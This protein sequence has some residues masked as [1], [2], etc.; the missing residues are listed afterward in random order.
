MIHHYSGTI[1][2]TTSPGPIDTS[3]IGSFTITYMATADAAGN[4]PIPVNATVEI[5]DTTAP[6]ITVS[7]LTI[8]LKIGESYTP[9]TFGV[10]DNDPAYSGTVTA[11][12]TPS[13]VD[14]SSIG[15]FTV[16][17]SAPADASG[18][19]PDNVTTTVSVTGCDADQILD[20]ATNT[21]IT[22]TELPTI[23]I[24]PTSFTLEIDEPFTPPTV[25]ISDNDPD[26]SGTISNT[27]SPGPIDTSR[28]GSFTITY[29]ATADAAGNSP[30]PVNATVEIV[31][32]TAPTITVSNL[33]ITLKIG[34]SYTPPT[35]G[36]TDND[37][38]YSG[39]VTVT[40]AP[41]PVDT[42][43]IGSFTVTHSAPADASGNIPDNVTT[44]VSVT[45][46]DP[47]Q[48]L[49]SNINACVIDT[50]SPDITVIP[51]SITLEIDEPFTPPT[52]TLM[53]NDPSYAGTISNTTSPGPIDTSRIGSFTITYMATADVAGNSPDNVIATVEIVDTTAPTITVSNL[54]ITLK[55]GESYTPPTFGVTDND[56]AYS[57]SV[58]AITTPSA[59]DTSS[60]GSFT[61]THSAPADASGNIPD[62]VTTT[63][64]V[65]GCDADQI[66][67]SATNTCIT[68]TE[69]PTIEI[70][71]TSFTLEIDEPFTPPTV[72]ISDN[73]PDYSG[74]ISNTTSP[75]PID[76]SRIGSFTITYMATADAAGNSP[77]NV[78]ATVEIVD[79]TAPTITVSNLTITLKI[80]ESY[81]PPTFGVTD[82][83]PAYSGTVTAITTPSAVDTSSIG[84]FTVTHSA[85]ADASGNIPDNVTTTVSVTGC[86]AD[87]ILDSATNTC[88]TDTELPTIEINPTSFT[89][90]I[91]EPFT[92]PTVTISDNDPDY[93]GTISNTTSPGPIDTSRIGSFTITYMATADAAGNSPIP[94][95]ATVEIVDTT[96]PTITVSNLTITLKIGESYTPPTFGVTDNDPAYS[97]T[98]TV[99]V[100]PNPVD[101]SSIGSFTVTHSAPADASGNIPDNVTT[102][103]SV[104]G[105]DADQILDSATNTCITDTELPTI[106]INPTSFT[107]EI[108]EPFTPPTVTISDNDPDYSGTISNTTSPGPIDTSRIGSFTITYMAT[109]DVAGNSPDN[110]IATVE[111]VDTTAPTITVSNLTI[112]LKIGE[113]YTPPTFGVTDNDPAYSGT[114][115][116]ITTPSAVDTSSI[117]SFT[118][119]HSAPADASGNIPDNV[120]TTVSVTGCDADQI[121]DSATNTCI[122]DTELPTIEINP[123]SFTLEIDEPFTPPTV[124]IS[125]NDPDYSGTISNTTSPGPIDTSRIG[126]F[127]ITYMA[128]A[129]AAGNSPIPVNATVEIVDTTAP[130][131]TVSNLTIT[132]KIGESYTPPTF[133]VTDNDPA[134]SGTVTAITTPSAVD[135]SS[136]GSFTV[137]HSAPADASGN[138]PDNVTTTVSVTGCDADQILDSATNTCITDTELPTIEINPTSFTLEIDEP[139]T[140]PTVT[141]SDN[142]PDYSGTISNTTSPGPIDTSRIGSFTITYMA[143]ADAAGNSP[144]PV[145]A[146]V[147]IV[148]TT[149][150]TITVSNLTI[151]LK[152]GE[153]YTPPTFGVTDNDP[154][155]SGTVTAITTPSA[156]DTSSIGSF[157]VTH[158]APADASGNIPDN[159]T[160]TVSVTGCD[161][162]QILDSAT[163]TCIT[164]TELPTIEINPTSFTLEIDEPFTPPTVTISDN[165]P[166]YSGTISNTTSPGPID[167][168]RIGS[169]TI[170]YMATADAA[171]N[172]PIPVN[173]TV[174]IVDTTAPTITVSNLT[175]T[176]KIGE[177]YTPPTFGVTDNDP[178]YSGSVTAITTPSAVDTSSI[179]SFTVTHSAPAD[180]SGNI[181]DNVTTTVSVTGCD[182]DQILD[183]AT[184]TCITDTELPTIEINPTS[185]TL[186]IDEPFTPPTVTISDNDPDYSGTIS[187]TTSPG[188]IDTSRI[189]SFTITYMA[190][191]DAAGNSPIPVNATVEIVD[192][193][194]PTI[195][196]SNLTITLK[197]G[198]SYTPPTFGVTDNDPAYS[199]TVTAITTPSAVDTSSIGSFT[200]T[201]SAP[202]DAS[203]NIPDNVTTTV[204]VTGCDADQILD[205]ATN[206]CIT[207]TELPTIEINPTSF[208]L[209]IDEPFTP[210]TV[211]ISDNDPDYSGTISN[212][213][214]PG[215]ID[216]SRIGSF[217]ITYMATA[218]AAGNSPI[219]VNA[220][221]E[222]VDTTAPTITVSNLT[223]T[224]KIGES[225]TPPTF[226]VTDNDPAYSGTVTVTVAPNPVDTSSIG[227]FTVTH[228][229]PADASGN[230]PDNVTTTVSVTG[231]DPNQILDSNINACVIDTESPDITVIPSSI[232]LEIDE[233]FTPPTVTLM[234]NDPSYAGTISNTTSPGPID[235]SRIG[236]F[237]I[238]YMATADVAGNS[239]DNVIATVEIVDT[240]APT[241]T[242]SNLT[243]TLK[244]GE[245]YTPPTFGV[246]DN[247]PAYSGSVT[248]ITTP[249]A[250]DT[251]SIGSFTVTHS[252][253]AD[254]SGNIPDNV[255]TTVSVTG[256]DADQILDSATN[257]CITDTELPTIEINPTSFTLEID[258]PFTPPTVT[259]S[260]N[261]PDYSGTISNTTSPGPIDTSRIGS[262]TITYMATADA[263]G[264]SPDNVIATVEIVDTT[265]PTITVSNLTITLKIGESYT[266]PT[267]G[268]TDN[269]PAYS[270]TVT[271]ITTPSAVDT[272]SIGS[273]TVTH[274]APADAS[275]NIPDNVTT[276]VSVTGCDADQILDSATN[277]CITDTELPTIEINPTSF[278]LEIDEP[279]TPPT[280]TISDNDPDYS[281]TISNTT[282]PGPIDTSRIGSFTITYMATADAA[283][284]SPIPVNA[285]VEIVDTTAPTITV[286]NL[287]ITLK[288]GESYTPPTFGVTDND[289]AYS[290]TVTA[291][292]TPSAV[293]TSS[294]GSFTV[295]HSAPADASGNIPD[296]VTTT[297]SVTG[298]DADQ[299]L[300]SATNTCITDTELPTI[301]IN[302]TS[303]TLEIDEP[304]TPPTVTISDNDP[305]YSGTISNTTSP[306]PIDTSRI[307]SFTITYMATADAAG[308]SPDNVNATV[309]IVDT[310]APTITVSNLTIT[311]KIGESYTPP[312]FGVTDNDPAYSGTVTAITTPSAVDTSSIG[313]FT[314]THSAPADASG[315]IPDNVTTTVSVTGCDADQILDSA[316]NTCITD[317]EL[318]TIEINPTSFTL[319]IDEPFT[320]PTVTISDN[321]PDYSGTISN[322]TSPGPIDTS[323]IGSFTITYMATADAAGNSPI[324]VNATV[325]I[326]DTTAPTI[327][328]S[329][330][331]I[332]LKIGESYT[333]PTFGVTD[334]DPAYSGTVTVT[335]APNPVDTSSIGSFTVTHSAPADASGNIPDNVTTTVSVT[336]CDADQILDS[337]TNTCITDTELPTIEINPTSFTLEIDEP[338]TPPTVTISDND[339]DTGTISNTTSPGP[340]DTSRIG[341]FTITYMATADVAGN[342]PDNV[343]AT[344][345]IVDTTAPTITVSNL[346]ITLKIGESYTPP[347]FGVTDNDP[348]YTGSVTAI[349]TPSAVDT[350]SIGSFTV[351]HSAPADASGNIPDNVTTT[352]SVTGCDADQIL[353]SATNT[354]ITDTELPTIEINPTSFTLEIDEPFTPPTVTISDNDPDYSGTISNTTSPG[355]IDT[356]RIGSFT[357]TYMATADVAGN[358]PDLMLLQL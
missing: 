165:D 36:V 1:S 48:I 119:T 237:T 6:T 103:V 261:D 246:T 322:T 16:T 316:T 105:C 151:T 335:V 356:S 185:F 143:T 106:E 92:P 251:S 9:P 355:P 216:T 308:N 229:A 256:C 305:D 175:I 309:E 128:T 200:V 168:S 212:T 275:G 303:F 279:F 89:L 108:D 284:N 96:A 23:E 170:T 93:S 317:T 201:H 59:V 115:T 213:T 122:T 300:D 311:L 357:I 117:G 65:T 8:T 177:S 219:P 192:T 342:S 336:G 66:L 345:E 204:S 232:T 254:A 242:V 135:T 206:T 313:S 2:N 209:E 40:V 337:A 51:S 253:P 110:V 312:T 52:V 222:I 267:F 328:V 290:G 58:T 268:V 285:T 182:A 178:A 348:A 67:D 235:T 29:M 11:I 91:D 70:N 327:T 147:E 88:I 287:T 64:S 340:I 194:A 13:A 56:P 76:T 196:V 20:S 236:S 326:V 187:N 207:D 223:I 282:S 280:V 133:G 341:S 288:I 130:T 346:T 255:T 302:P 84:S 217:T 197:I 28:I 86:D 296:N 24:N 188:P 334:N 144:I 210:P 77:D 10:T 18:N 270:G 141:I 208:T 33:T 304:F 50:E 181:P 125:D 15:S 230:I 114:V 306:G 297:V 339:P 3:R 155:Y 264:N 12:T 252:A 314:V 72:T 42:S 271:A 158:S 159:V 4:S 274:S 318:P 134:Y 78:I 174:E 63:V 79:T 321:D 54:T 116:A 167:T 262:F 152:I 123:T 157:T 171:G 118:V 310:T 184:N 27:T 191:A 203:G 199:G 278:T 332:T 291:I 120:T 233:P 30:I 149:A 220:T 225:Y 330:L 299:I 320:P 324:P 350:S 221:V 41:N 164:D 60:I 112:T 190:T 211:T 281:G 71:P 353:D 241:I 163:N 249:S 100:A 124:T 21:C 161:A 205:S 160:T 202:A 87:Q 19:I 126:S 234:D 137:T 195:T 109:A 307:G 323:R 80:G 214:S 162:D 247:D 44:T 57:G 276:T 102:T 289:P 231:C 69:L 266:P 215:P 265:A 74:T 121:L 295:T 25:T 239:P 238:T 46:C 277:T 132:L 240:T 166:D 138:I 156:V 272:S 104:T 113:S 286:S 315:N 258:E 351:T 95:N 329:N 228:S 83:D 352:V 224:L 173:A 14:T 55:I 17:H 331:T 32:T 90:E 189:G 358:S 347:T 325:E 154:A 193:T 31:D 179:G 338:F 259:I 180:A 293:D 47:N 45:G 39:T 82:N 273:F 172:S 111:I 248:A 146:T 35:F 85:P 183:S 37:P 127:T 354:C 94:V 101:T 218:D 343:I 301:E 349:T 226:G 7:N 43:S 153:S 49:D 139:F 186:E 140:P 53:D 298:C 176:L 227:S 75:G 99:T 169:F 68:D 142:D 5:V 107:L 260:D 97:G 294:I 344:V 81:T 38:A 292:T 263:A 319:E 131:I 62:N 136:I 145:N 150:P 245:S 22:D 98:V 34:E 129:D 333:P 198:E 61:V 73:D 26:Y 250:V 257:T 244:I 269:D 283:G 243:I 148:D